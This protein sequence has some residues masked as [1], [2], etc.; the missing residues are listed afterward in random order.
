MPSISDIENRKM[1]WMWN[2]KL[3]SESGSH[4]GGSPGCAPGLPDS[5][6]RSI[7]Y[8]CH[9]SLRKIPS[10][11]ALPRSAYAALNFHCGQTICPMSRYSCRNDG[12][13]NV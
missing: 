7:L 12:I 2:P 4:A 5:L 3:F 10:P 9:R 6:H 8:G 1:L 11:G 13:D